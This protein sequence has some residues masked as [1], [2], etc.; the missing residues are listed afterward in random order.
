ML[1]KDENKIQIKRYLYEDGSEV[2][3]N[4][5]D[6]IS[7]F[8]KEHDENK[9]NSKLC[10]ITGEKII[11]PH[12]T[13]KCG[14]TFNY[15]PLYKDLIN[16][17]TKFQILDT[18]KLGLQVVRCPYCRSKQDSLLPFYD[19]PE[20]KK[21]HG[22]NWLDEESMKN[23]YCKGLC[24]FVSP[25]LDG[26]YLYCVNN[27][28]IKMSDGKSYCLYH[29]KIMTKKTLKE[30]EKQ[31][32]AKQKEEAKKAWIEK[33]TKEKAEKKENI[34]LCQTVLKSGTRKG[35]PCYEK[36]TQEGFCLRHLKMKNNSEK[37]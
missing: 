7:T 30:K 28:V 37:K 29:Q 18:D 11:D 13:M 23:T 12:V 4:I 10:L 3:F 15:V 34:V 33:K 22:I 21:I 36:A 6:I 16:Q 8:S 19:L 32:K 27:Y 20:V 35:E 26:N 5:K 25:Y 9:E 1:K 31:E 24:E 2:N 14:H 17:K